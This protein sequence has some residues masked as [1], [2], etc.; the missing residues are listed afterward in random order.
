M[1]ENLK[2]S[3][4]PTIKAILKKKKKLENLDEMDGFLDRCHI[5][6]LNQEQVSYLNTP[7]LH[8]EI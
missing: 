4:D 6:K 8:K 5:P 3:S 7:I 1:V 2:K